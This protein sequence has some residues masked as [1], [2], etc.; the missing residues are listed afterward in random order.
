MKNILRELLAAEQ[1]ITGTY[2]ANVNQVTPRTT[3]DDIKHLD[4]ILHQHGATIVSVISKGYKLE[5]NDEKHFRIFLQSL[6][7]KDHTKDDIPTT[8][9][10]RVSYII[11]RLLLNERYIKLDDLAD[12][13]YVSRSTIQADL[14]TVKQILHKYGI[15]LEPRPNYGLKATGDEM[16]FRFC[17]SEYLFDRDEIKVNSLVETPLSPIPVEDL[18][19]IQAIIMKQLYEHEI[20]LSDIAIHNLL[21]HIAIAYKRIVSKH[22]VALVHQDIDEITKQKEY[23]VA[24]KI[25]SDVEKLFHVKFPKVEIA[26]ITMHLL[27]I[28][29][30]SQTKNA[31]D[32]VLSKEIIQLINL[33][34]YRIDEQLELGIQNDKK[35]IMDLGLHLKPAINRIKFGMNIRNP[36]LKD[37][38]NNYPLAYE[39]G[40]IA[41]LTI[42]E[43][44][45]VEI[46]ENE[47]G[48]LALHIGAAIER[49]KLKTGPK[50]CL[51]VCASGLGTA[52]LIYYRLKSYFGSN[53]EVVGTTPLY[54][55][56]DIDL[57]GIDFIV[58]SIL[59]KQS[60]DIPVIQV[61]AVLKEQDLKTIERF[62]FHQNS[63]QPL[64]TYFKKELTFL[65]KRFDSQGEALEFL[66]TKL[67][68]QALVDETFI[69]AVY[70]REQI[71]STAFG[72]FVAIPHPITP[73]TDQTFVSVCTLKKPIDWNGTLVQIIFLLCV[74]KNS[75][76]DLQEMYDLLGKIIENKTLVQNI[77]KA[78]MFEDFIQVIKE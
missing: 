1:P 66:N 34:L 20:S 78:K 64:L 49:K 48:Y 38:K 22:Y 3:R 29:L 70:K 4:A 21:I 19:K 75:Q 60:I 73:K 30:L 45:G 54:K 62:L 67:I 36:M 12:E 13:L 28:K 61:N 6:S 35:L 31:V 15:E 74:K 50:R 42:K 68:D 23:K 63:K 2:L 46:D 55:L 24:K 72:N 39:A 44:I 58:S 41:G 10:E 17:L 33:I 77:L 52:Q 57:K 5:V 7:Y 51:V 16:R 47:I 37:I 11:R 14:K 8:P 40:I 9:E 26:Y 59:I 65:R 53:L 27:G 56:K 71:A 32:D 69:E 43:H 18:D 25:V 76:E